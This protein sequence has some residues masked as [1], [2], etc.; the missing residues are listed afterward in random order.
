M[1][2]DTATRRSTVTVTSYAER[3]GTGLNDRASETNTEWGQP[4]AG[5]LE[6]LTAAGF[7]AAEQPFA[8]HD[9]PEKDDRLA[10]LARKR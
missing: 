5:I 2:Y 7:D 3:A 1:V 10:I 8:Q 6:R 9:D 4:V